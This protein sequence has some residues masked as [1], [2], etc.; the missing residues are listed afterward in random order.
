MPANTGE[1]TTKAFSYNLD[2]HNMGRSQTHIRAAYNPTVESLP[3][4]F[5]DTPAAFGVHVIITH[6]WN[7]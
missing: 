2:V 4:Q 1:N 5:H 6:G 7:S 3:P